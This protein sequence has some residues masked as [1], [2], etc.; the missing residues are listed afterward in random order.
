VTSARKLYANR[1]NARASTG[2][3]TAAGKKR[4]TRNALRHGLSLSVLG[5]PILSAEAANLAREIAGEGATP[6]V[7]ELARRVAEAQID[8][9]RIREARH[10]LLSRDLNDPEFK[11]HNYFKD[12]DAMMISHLRRFGPDVPFHLS[13][14]NMP[15][16][17]R[18]GR[19]NLHAS[20][21]ISLRSSLRWIVMNGAHSRGVNLRS[22]RLIRR[23]PRPLHLVQFL[24]DHFDRSRT[25]H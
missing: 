15:I 8:L 3:R 7:V 18:K 2:P 9:I 23:G 6:D 4:A 17:N 11:P 12:V 14:H 24:D 19:K 16:G 25:G 1:A 20:C 13:K 22:A 5:N 10:D 21:L